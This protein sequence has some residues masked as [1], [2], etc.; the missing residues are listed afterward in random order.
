MGDSS[1]SR[2]AFC[3]SSPVVQGVDAPGGV[4]KMP[5]FEGALNADQIDLVISYPRDEQLV[6]LFDA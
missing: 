6:R 2:P 5:A 1:V 4:D 3:R